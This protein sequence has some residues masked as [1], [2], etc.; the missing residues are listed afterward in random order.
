[1]TASK[2]D[3]GRSSPQPKPGSRARIAAKR[4]SWANRD[5]VA[6]ARRLQRIYRFSPYII[7]LLLPGGLALL[8]VIAWWRHRFGVKRP[9]SPRR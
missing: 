6:A 1:M 3:L 5:K 9:A 2:H 8:P 7:A 4:R